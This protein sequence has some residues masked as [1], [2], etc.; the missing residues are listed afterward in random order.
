MYKEKIFLFQRNT[1]SD[2]AMDCNR[3]NEKTQKNICF[4]KILEDISLNIHINI[5]ID[6]RYQ[7]H[8]YTEM[9]P[10]DLNAPKNII[11]QALYLR[12]ILL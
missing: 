8:Y 7:K 2:F 12:K 3:H 1:T 5:N 4:L 9:F 11:N 10:P 6:K